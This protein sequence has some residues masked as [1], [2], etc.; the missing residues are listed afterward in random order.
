MQ[1]ATRARELEL[2]YQARRGHAPQISISDDNHHV[3]EAIGDL[4]GDEDDYVPK[5]DSRPLSFISSPLG[6]SLETAPP[7]FDA[8]RS[9]PPRSPLSLTQSNERTPPAQ[10]NGRPKMLSTRSSSFGRENEPSPL[11]P[12]ALS[13]TNSDTANQ[14]FPLNDI[15]YE[16]SPAAVAQELSNLQAIRR[17]SMD[18]NASDPDLPS[19]SSGFSVPSV[20]PPNFTDDEDPSKL[21][22]VPARLHPELAP[23]EFKTFIEEK[24]DK[25]RR[26][27]GG[28]DSLSPDSIGRSGS[29]SGSLKRK[30]SMLSRQVDGPNNYRDG[31]DRLERKR[32]EKIKGEGST[33][34]ADLQELE[35]LVEDPSSMMRRMSIDSA[36]RTS[37]DSGIELTSEDMPILPPK[38]AGQPTLKRSTRTNYRRGSLRKG[39]RVPFSRRMAGRQSETDTEES[40]VSSPTHNKHPD[41]PTIGLSRVQTEPIHLRPETVENFSRP[42][43]KRSP[44]IT[45]P[46]RKSSEDQPFQQPL[47]TKSIPEQEPEPQSRKSPP[48]KPF[49]SRIASNGRTTAPLPGYTAPQSVPQIIETP[50]P[51]QEPQRTSSLQLPERSSSREAHQPRP[52]QSQAPPPRQLHPPRQQPARPPMHRTG[53]PPIKTDNRTIEDMASHPSPLPGNQST[54]TDSLSFIPTFN[55]EKEKK[56]DKKSKDKKDSEGGSRKTS[57]GW[58]LGGEDKQKE[59]ER[60]QKEKEEAARKAKIKASKAVD[61]SH[62]NTRLD[63]LQS[64][65]DGSK[66]RES[67][68]IDRESLKLEEER[69]KESTRKSGGETK[70]EKSGIFSS[71]FGGEKKKAEKETSHKKGSSMRGLSP[72]PPP[73]IL[74]PDIDYNW[75]RFSIMEERAI[76]RMAHIKL[77]NPRRE[78]YSQVLLSN[79][80]YSYLAKVQQMH[81]QMQIGQKQQQRQAQQQ[82]KKDQPEEFSQYQRYQQANIKQQQDQAENKKT[83]ATQE[84]QGN[85]E[86]PDH[87]GHGQARP[88]SRTS[89]HTQRS[90]QSQQSQ[91]SQHSQHSQQAQQ[92]HSNSNGNSYSVSSGQDY[93]G[94]PRNTPQSK[95]PPPSQTPYYGDGMFD[96]ESPSEENKMW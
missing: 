73:R 62:D 52:V 83:P 61:K 1:S 19:F 47:T 8:A 55:D 34:L 71:L 68:V 28:E 72:E 23:K 59:R 78:L 60:E 30:K 29:G 12:P 58:L 81:P 63:V 66:G 37:T 40:P 88:D 65:I 51:P 84:D 26:R 45:P 10:V 14:Q 95:S 9:S 67:I 46:L 15:D 85:Q 64:S 16:S 3:T 87:E 94:Q 53:T 20:A 13:R 54:R 31:A 43:R 48:T 89:Q 80:M 36:A 2:M 96:D 21:F 74:K 77:A 4:Y 44:P 82:Q 22:W 41:L 76:Y 7:S 56:P 70:K 75:T 25:I 79:F 17:M 49:H 35:Q 38:S 69:K 57:W 93:L 24:V 33:P 18:V 27:S 6:E 42:G 5:R 39:E 32:S 86:I 11:S 92:S 91:N 50:P 90:Q